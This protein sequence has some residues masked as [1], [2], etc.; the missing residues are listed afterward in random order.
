MKGARH[1]EDRREQRLAKTIVNLL[2]DFGG[3]CML[4]LRN[5]HD[6]I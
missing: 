6:M 1:R 2:D 5:C 4:F 3:L